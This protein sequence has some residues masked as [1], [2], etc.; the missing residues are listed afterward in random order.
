MSEHLQP[1]SYRP[2]T[3]HTF[4]VPPSLVLEVGNYVSIT[5]R[6]LMPSM[7]A[8]AMAEAGRDA[9]SLQQALLKQSLVKA[10]RPDGSVLQMSVADDSVDRFLTEIGPKGR[11]LLTLAYGKISNPEVDELNFFLKGVQTSVV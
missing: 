2:A 11:G 5:L 4:P 7:E 9:A 10:A 6:E 1:K 3:E 8:R